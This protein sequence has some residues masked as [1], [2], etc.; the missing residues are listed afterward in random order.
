[1]R[2]IFGV[3]SKLQLCEVDNEVYNIL[4]GGTRHKIRGSKSA[5]ALDCLVW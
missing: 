1:M 3:M 2:K 4:G 5:E